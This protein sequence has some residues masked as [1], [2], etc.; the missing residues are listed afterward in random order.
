MTFDITVDPSR[1]E[2]TSTPRHALEGGYFR[3]VDATYEVSPRGAERCAVTLT[4]RYVAKSSVNVYEELWASAVVGDFQ[5]RVLRVLAERF[6]RW[7][8]EGR[9]VPVA[10]RGAPR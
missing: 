4:S 2:T 6:A 7:H 8:R 3:F 5:D 9:P 10:Q 1:L